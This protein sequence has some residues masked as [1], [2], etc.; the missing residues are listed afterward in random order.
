MA[1]ISVFSKGG[2]GWVRH[3]HSQVKT[4]SI[5]LFEPTMVTPSGGVY[6]KGGIVRGSDTSQTYP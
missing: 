6:L 2:H 1:E 5:F 4:W 3:V